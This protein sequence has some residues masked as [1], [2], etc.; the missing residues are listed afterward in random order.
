MTVASDGSI[1]LYA[2]TSNTSN[3][4]SVV[5]GVCSVNVKNSRGFA[6]PSTGGRGISRFYILGI[7]LIGIAGIGLFIRRRWQISENS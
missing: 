6:L 5:D 2:Q 3:E 1:V 4:F 7:M